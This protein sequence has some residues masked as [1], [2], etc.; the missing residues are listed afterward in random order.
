LPLFM[1]IIKSGMAQSGNKVITIDDSV[2]FFVFSPHIYLL[3]WLS[4]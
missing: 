3:G 2:F 4:N 1:L